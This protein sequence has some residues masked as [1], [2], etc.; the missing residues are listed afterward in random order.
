VKGEADKWRKREE[1]SKSAANISFEIRRSN[2]DLDYLGMD[3]LAITAEG[4]EAKGGVGP[5][6][7][8]DAIAY[9]PVRNAVGHTGLLTQVAKNHL[10]TTY[11]N[12]KAR[13]RALLKT[14][15]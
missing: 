11:E 4:P 12:I 5:S 2:V 15:P 14:L 8:R 9:K 13:V 6:L 1:D 3:E 7:W 10:A